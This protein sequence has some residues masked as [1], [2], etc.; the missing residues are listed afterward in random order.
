MRTRIFN[1]MTA[2]EVEEYLA[3][4]G[5]T[6]F[7]ALGVVEVHGAMPI[8]CEGTLPEAIALAL[9]EETDGLAMINLPYFFPG[10]TIISNATVQ[11]SVR[12]SIDYLM[13]IGRSLVSQGF[14]KIFFLSGH[15]PAMLYI[16][17]MCR[18]FFQETKVHVCHLNL[19]YMMRAFG[20]DMGFA[21]FDTMICG[22]YKMLNQIDY[23]AVD[24][25]G[26]E[27]VAQRISPDSV[28]G[29]LQNAVKEL[30]GKSSIYYEIPEQHFGGK[31][32]ASEAERL[33]VCTKGEEAIRTLAK[34]AAP[35]VERL[36]AALDKYHVYVQEILKKYPHAR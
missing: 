12:D 30:G 35:A 19:M 25:N 14:D 13:M 32:F 9:A 7:V 11:V 31:P 36:K 21:G 10:G 15:A 16:D 34:N 26:K 29:E 3:R 2:N 8:D 17:A 20:P 28:L 5:K 23:L 22:A 24:P 6:I 18:D 27:I 1:K 4:G 33:E